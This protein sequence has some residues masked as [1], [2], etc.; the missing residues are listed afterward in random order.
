[1]TSDEARQALDSIIGSA[2]EAVEEVTGERLLVKPSVLDARAADLAAMERQTEHYRE[3]M[4]LYRQW[5]TP[6]D[7]RTLGALLKV[8]PTE[9]AHEITGHLTAAG[10]L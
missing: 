9:V 10:L 6:G 5:W 7:R 1:M 4:R 8:I 3:A 2:V